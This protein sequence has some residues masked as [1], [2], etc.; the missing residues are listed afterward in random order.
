[1]LKLCCNAV[2][3]SAKTILYAEFGDSNLFGSY[4]AE[5]T[6]LMRIKDLKIP[7]ELGYYIRWL[8]LKFETTLNM[9]QQ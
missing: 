4:F 3:V 6:K 1:L 8:H 9:N 2:Y 5:E 7:K